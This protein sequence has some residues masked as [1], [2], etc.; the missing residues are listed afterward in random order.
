MRIEKVTCDSCG[1]DLTVRTNSVDYR[2]VLKSESKPGY[3]PGF[4][5]DMGIYPPVDRIYHFCALKCLDHWRDH[6]RLYA[7][8]RAAKSDAWAEEHGTVVGTAGLDN[9][10]LRSYPCPPEDV[11]KAWE[12]ECRAEASATFPLATAGN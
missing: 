5:T 3:G 7:K 11:L 1:K 4:Y 2:L 6:E 9:R 12:A 8:L 10:P